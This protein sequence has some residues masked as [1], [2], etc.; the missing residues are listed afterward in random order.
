MKSVYVS[1]F[2]PVSGDIAVTASG[3][4]R[5]QGVL[6][7]LVVTICCIHPPPGTYNVRVREDGSRTYRAAPLDRHRKKEADA[8]LRVFAQEAV[9]VAER[10]WQAKVRAPR[11][12]LFLV[13]PEPGEA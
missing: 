5:V 9:E 2:V 1:V 3:V 11:P 12:A 6:G 10:L 7:S 8:A 13:E 4:G